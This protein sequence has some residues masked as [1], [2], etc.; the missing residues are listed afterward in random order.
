MSH[1]QEYLAMLPLD[2]L[3]DIIQNMDIV[4]VQELQKACKNDN[5][6]EAVRSECTGRLSVTKYLDRHFG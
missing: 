1:S 3:S 6:Y 4:T 5:R 2:I